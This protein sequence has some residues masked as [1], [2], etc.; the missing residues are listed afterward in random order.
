[1]MLLDTIDVV[2][3]WTIHF[4]DY[5]RDVELNVTELFQMCNFLINKKI[6]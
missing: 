6:F 4:P 5:L 3:R 2:G 1:M